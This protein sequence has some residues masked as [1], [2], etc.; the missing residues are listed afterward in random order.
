MKRA[1]KQIPLVHELQQQGPSADKLYKKGM[2]T[3]ALHDRYKNMKGYFDREFPEVQAEAEALAPGWG[4][5]IWMQ[6]NQLF[7]N[8]RRQEMEAQM[9]S[10]VSAAE[11]ES[12]IASITKNAPQ[13]MGPP[14]PP[15]AQASS[16]AAVSSANNGKK[17]GA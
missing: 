10:G 11:D 3:D 12:I 13:P 6:A 14:R 4:G 5:Q 16:P 9:Q 2:I 17:T 8:I 1:F 7:L 15:S